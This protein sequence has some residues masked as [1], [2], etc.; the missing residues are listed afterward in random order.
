MESINYNPYSYFID[1]E[2]KISK[3]PMPENQ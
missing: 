3:S 1:E 2:I